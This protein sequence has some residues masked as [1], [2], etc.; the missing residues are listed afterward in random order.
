[1][2]K[3]L[4][5]ILKLLKEEKIIEEELKD[6]AKIIFKEIVNEYESFS[7]EFKVITPLTGIR[8]QNDKFEL[9]NVVLKEMNEKYIE[10]IIENIENIVLQ[11]NSNEQKNEGFIKLTRKKLN[12]LKGIVCSEYII[13][14]EPL[15][16]KE[17]AEEETL[18]IL[19]LLRYSI[20]SLYNDN[21]VFIGLQGE[22]GNSR[23]TPI[24]STDKTSFKMYSEK[25][26][27]KRNYQIDDETIEYL[28][29]IGVFKLS[30]LFKKNDNDLTD[31]ENTLLR[32][33]QWFSSVEKQYNIGNKFLS[34]TVSLETLL[35][36]KVGIP[37]SNSLAEG[38]AFLLYSDKDERK[39][40]KKRVKELYGLRSDVFH[41]IGDE[42]ISHN[43]FKDLQII[44][45]NLIMKLTQKTHDFNTKKELLY[46]VEDV[47]FS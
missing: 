42:I 28:E 3:I 33:V 37:I 25:V 23:I 12:K 31:F 39:R 45:G 18:I 29:E 20:P 40:V 8:L 19:D 46:F 2:Q 15:K 13:E 21:T 41:G 5:K 30:E 9:G 26:D 6:H 10:E 27:N 34:L 43:D 4:T 24:I 47:K 7:E 22:I 17:K 36:P 11:G 35:T 38:I 44:L 32:S 1:M 14:A 16:A